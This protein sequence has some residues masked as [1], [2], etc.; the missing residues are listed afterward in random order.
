MPSLDQLEPQVSEWT[1]IPDIATT[2]NSGTIHRRAIWLAAALVFVRFSMLNELAGYLAGVHLYLLYL[3]GIPT[4]LAVI[5]KGDLRDT[6]RKAPAVFWIAFGFWLVVATPTSIWKGGSAHLLLGYFKA[7]LLMLFVVGALAQTWRDCKLLMHVIAAAAVM[8]LAISRIFM[9]TIGT[10]RLD[11][12]FGTVANANDFAAHLLLVLPFLLWIILSSSSRVLRLIALLGVSY[13][14]YV[15]LAS[16][17][18]GA[19]VAL[20]A[21]L[22]FFTFHADLRHRVALWILAP[23]VLVVGFTVLPHQVARRLMSFSA[24]D[25][26]ASQEALASSQAREALLRDSIDCALH[27]PILGIGP[28]QF[29]FYEGTHGVRTAGTYWH[30]AHNSYTA[31]ASEAGI[32]ALFFYVAALWSSWRLL[33]RNLKRSRSEHQ[34]P[35]ISNAILCV[36]I[37]V[38]G[39]ATATF[40]LNFTYT[41]YLPAMS[42][43]AIALN[44]ATAVRSNGSE[45][46]GQNAPV[47]LYPAWNGSTPA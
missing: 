9:S 8:N 30:N 19:L 37:A 42:G 47:A 27:N 44:R 28:G 22:L 20:A 17:S 38:L 3:V 45:E 15:V 10:G 1:V 25:P 40:F 35:E 16:G 21:D 29:T 13:G 31:A 5:A 18:R 36:M 12:E 6:L 41:F 7:E 24:S 23:L 33:K 11:L 32:P 4:I 14:V 2:G 34:A 26:D 39:F 43:L 46:E